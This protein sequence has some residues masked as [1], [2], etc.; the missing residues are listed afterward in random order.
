MDLGLEIRMLHFMTIENFAQKRKS[1][2]PTSEAKILTNLNIELSPLYTKAQG[3]TLHQ[4]YYA[5][6]ILGENRLL[7]LNARSGR[8]VALLQPRVLPLNQFKSVNTYSLTK[9]PARSTL[10]L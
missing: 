1:I 6:M 4:F 5:L 7:N 3:P 9:G 10:H 8:L 2:I